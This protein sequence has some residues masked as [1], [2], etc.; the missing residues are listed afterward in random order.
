MSA[1]IL[2]TKRD[3]LVRRSMQDRAIFIMLKS[4]QSNPWRYC[5]KK[6]GGYLYLTAAAAASSACRR[7]CGASRSRDGIHDIFVS[8][9]VILGPITGVTG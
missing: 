6:I 1:V 3:P 5:Q 4:S 2:A 9:Q 8:C 7:G